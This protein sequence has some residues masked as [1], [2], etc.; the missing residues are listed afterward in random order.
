[1]SENKKI[2]EISYLLSYNRTMKKLIVNKKYD[3]INI[4]SVILSYKDKYQGNGK[5]G[6]S[7]GMV[8]ASRIIPARL[9][10]DEVEEIEDLSKKAFRILNL[11]GVCRIDFLIDKDSKKIYINEPNTC[12]GS[13]SFYL[14]EPK[15]KKYSELLDDMITLAIKRFKSRNEKTY[16]FDTNVLANFNGLKGAKG[17][18]GK[19]GK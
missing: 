18:M 5:G 13:L 15:G 6:K 12:P 7:K 9:T 10:K 1:M 3:N 11:S 4:D 8:S 14:W 17:K 19:F 2:L 16:S